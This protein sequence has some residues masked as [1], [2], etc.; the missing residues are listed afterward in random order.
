MLV[1]QSVLFYSCTSEAPRNRPTINL[2]NQN[3]VVD[4]EKIAEEEAQAELDRLAALARPTN[5]VKIENGF[6]ACKDSLS[7]SQGNCSA[8]CAGKPS[9]DPKLYL[10]VSTT[11][12]IT[13][14]DDIKTFH[15][16][17]TKEIPD[18]TTGESLE[19]NPSCLI[20]VKDSDNNTGSLTIETISA[21]S[22]AV[23]VNIASLDEDKTYRIKI[24]ETVSGAASSTV[25]IRKFSTPITDP[26]G[27]ALGTVPIQQYTCMNI[28]IA[29]DGSNLFY[30]DASRI[31]FYFNDENRPEPLSAIFANIHCH[32]INKYGKTPINNP[33]LEESPGAYS[34]WNIWDPRFWD[35][36]GDGEA[37][38]NQLLQQ[39]VK[40]QGFTMD[41]P[42]RLFHK[43]QWY[44]GPDVSSAST[45]GSSSGAS[46][47]PVLAELGYYMTPWIDQTT[48]KAYCPK[49]SHY[50][51]SNQLFVA[52]RDLVG[53]DTEGLYIAKQEGSQDFILIREAVLK[54]IWFYKVSGQHIEPTNDTVTGKQVQFYWPADPASPFIKKSHQSIYTV[55]KA[56]EVG[57]DNVSTDQQNSTGTSSN[58]PPHDKRIGCIPAL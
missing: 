25:Q 27:G 7:I 56:S 24:V 47:A 4:E 11:E 2:T 14:R 31:H 8:F 22:N 37:Q 15:N 23:V 36:D 39:N 48:F 53:V 16:W 32:D 29:E 6:C 41:E 12:D 42:P 38:I 43:F 34:L 58:Y 20:E 26:I 10:T 13:Q 52:M 1:L 54:E 44:N 28:T 35:T 3:V 30:E 17:C 19:L 5:A 18:P 46:A 50:Y 55:K 45:S 57:S 40:D 21:G 33:L 51:S 49:R 9:A